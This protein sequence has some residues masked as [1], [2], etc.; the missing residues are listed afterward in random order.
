MSTELFEVESIAVAPS[1]TLRD[2]YNAACKR[3][4]HPPTARRRFS[5]YDQFRAAFTSA[6]DDWIYGENTIKAHSLS[7]LAWKV[8]ANHNDGSTTC[9]DFNERTQRLYL[10]DGLLNYLGLLKDDLKALRERFHR[11]SKRL[12][13]PN[14]ASD[15]AQ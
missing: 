1:P 11:P 9:L 8:L 6:I 12:P 2:R 15:G 7:D 14:V 10:G 13:R 5:E 4:W 3:C